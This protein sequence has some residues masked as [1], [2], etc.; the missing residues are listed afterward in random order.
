MLRLILDELAI[1]EPRFREEVGLIDPLSR[2][3][4]WWQEPDGVL[5]AIDKKR[6]HKIIMENSEKRKI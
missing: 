6:L 3:Y 2:W 1:S 5:L 4:H